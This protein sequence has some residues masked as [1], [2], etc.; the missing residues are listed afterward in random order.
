MP[1]NRL[2]NQGVC[3]FGL[4]VVCAITAWGLPDPCTLRGVSIAVAA[5]ET[6][7]QLS[8]P[9]VP[10]TEP[11]DTAATF[12]ALHGFRMDLLAAEPLVTDPV[13]I[14]YDPDGRAF[15]VEMSDYPYTDKSTDKAFTERTT[16]LPLGKVRLLEDV[17]GDGKFDRSTI[18]ARELSWP[19]GIALWRGGCFVAATPDI[20]YLK[21]TD[22]DG[23]ADVR[24]R[25]FTGFRKFNVQATMNNLKWGLDG[26]IYGAGGSNGGT[27]RREAD[28]DA[29]PIVLGTNDYRFHPD[30]EQ[31]EV[32][33]GGARFGLTFDDWGNRF[34][35]NIRNPVQHVVLPAEALRRNPHL[36]VRTA[37][38][39]AAEAGDTLPVFRSS[40][41]EAWRVANAQRL[42]RDTTVASPRSES[43]ATGYMTSAC[44]I[45]I[46]RGSAYPPEFYG[47]VF[48]AEPAANLIH[49][50]ILKPNGVTFTSTRADPDAEFVASTDNWFRPV[51]F[52]NAPDGTLHVCDMYRETIEHPWSIPDD[53]KAHLD[54][55]SGR[56]RGRIYR[57]TPPNFKPPPKPKLSQATTAELVAHL[58][59]P[60]SWWRE[61]AQRLL[62]ER[63]ALAAVASLRTILHA[64]DPSK[65]ALFQGNKLDPTLARLH[66]LWTLQSLNHLGTEDMLLGMH[67]PH[68]GVRENAV[69]IAELRGVPVAFDPELM[70]LMIDEDIRVRFRVALA[71]GAIPE[72]GSVPDKHV[73][74]ALETIARRDVADE[75]VRAAVLSSA[76][77]RSADLLMAIP[78]RDYSDDGESQLHLLR[79]LAVIAGTRGDLKELS[80]LSRHL[81]SLAAGDR[82]AANAIFLREMLLGLGDGFQRRGKRLSELAGIDPVWS[83][84]IADLVG[85][86]SRL[87]TDRAATDDER[88]QTIQLLGHGDA[89]AVRWVLVALLE[90]KQPQG[91]QLAAIRTLA[92][93]R[94]AETPATLLA[95]YRGATPGVRAEV[96]NTLLSRP[97]WING[98]LD[99]IEAGTVAATDVP[100]ARRNLLLR[101]ANAAIKD[102]ALKLFAREAAGPR[103]AVLKEYQA[104]LSLAG[105]AAR[106]KQVFQRECKQCHRVGDEG[107]DVGPSLATVRHR[108]PDEILLHVLDPNREVGPNFVEYVVVLTDG[109]TATGLI[110]SETP[111]SLTL[112][113]A[114]GAT[115]TILRRDID[116][117]SS[118]G[119][120][121]M[122]EGVE[123]KI[124]IA[125]MADLIAFLRGGK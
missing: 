73:S 27:I 47:N 78:L 72:L 42:A 64:H 40:P 107:Q 25:V 99:A 81:L 123:K 57:L 60:N 80:R 115:E 7:E 14:E 121:L 24:R 15:V 109:R 32:I 77:D 122:P 4:L 104:A 31:F 108:G 56:D 83:K 37:V 1:R 66:S 100:L 118:T 58:A 21:D 17:D 113:R 76:R 8:F 86:A 36:A 85:E 101:N 120:S 74:K 92:G 96:I 117:I 18:F 33:P 30:T 102:R 55:E 95:T 106:G 28:S 43:T 62:I 61:T 2:G 67:D 12:R 5:E 13:A 70:S 97:E 54:L 65:I 79:E 110:A 34:I 3:R 89:K 87:A 71:L 52:I 63:N 22:G 26:W 93:F 90:P 114:E 48:L 46:Y 53:I 119:K 98:L 91:V 39:D 23:V 125:E 116:E 75:W 35:C 41:P 94:Q 49:R 45:T 105:D 16:D 20:W 112:R 103:E 59:N 50:Q 88:V 111:T 19:T 38:H 84:L 44:G 10:P 9:R 82:A 6:N 51:N 124:P 11:A 68:P 29:K 69:R